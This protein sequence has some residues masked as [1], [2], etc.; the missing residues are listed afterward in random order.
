[1]EFIVIDPGSGH[2]FELISGSTPIPDAIPS[3]G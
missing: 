3:L 1:M 2:T